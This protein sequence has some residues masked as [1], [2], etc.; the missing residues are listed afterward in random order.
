MT[1]Y[2]FALVWITSSIRSWYVPGSDHR[3]NWCSTSLP[4]RYGI[5][6]SRALIPP[7]QL[8]HDLFGIGGERSSSG[9]SGIDGRALGVMNEVSRAGRLGGQDASSTVCRFLGEHPPSEPR[10]RAMVTAGIRSL[11][12]LKEEGGF[13]CLVQLLHDPMWARRAA[14]AL[15]DVGDPRAVP[16]LLAA[17]ALCKAAGWIRSCRRTGR[18]QN[19][20]SK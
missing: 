5:F 6:G 3:S 7:T 18:R 19:V 17:F 15:G 14:E 9:G 12:R 4:F 10:Y 13:E 8:I 2:E 11:G 20:I 16:D 1:D